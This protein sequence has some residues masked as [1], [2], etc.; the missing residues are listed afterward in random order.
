MAVV[1]DRGIAGWELE[2]AV[3]SPVG[4]AAETNEAGLAYG[5]DYGSGRRDYRA[6]NS[7]KMRTLAGGPVMRTRSKLLPLARR[8]RLYSHEELSC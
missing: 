1:G 7:F 5:C 3:G 4:M 2:R 6:L 8:G